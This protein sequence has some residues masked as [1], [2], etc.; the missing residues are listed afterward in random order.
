MEQDLSWIWICIAAQLG[1]HFHCNILG[2][3]CLYVGVQYVNIKN[4][5][6][7]NSMVNH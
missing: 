5:V 1:P 4:V 3:G 7:E 6:Q 2:E